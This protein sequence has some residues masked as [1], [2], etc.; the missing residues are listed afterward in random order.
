MY[1]LHHDTIFLTLSLT[2]GIIIMKGV[3]IGV[4]WPKPC[5]FVC[6]ELHVDNSGHLTSAETMR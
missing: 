2:Y 6:L 4:K 5:I 1:Y 3:K